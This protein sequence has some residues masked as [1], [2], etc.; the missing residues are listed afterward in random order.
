MDEDIDIEEIRERWKENERKKPRM[1]KIWMVLLMAIVLL[2]GYSAAS[3]FLF[4]HTIPSTSGAVLTTSCP[5]SLVNQNLPPTTGTGNILFMCSSGSAPIISNGGNAIPS[6]TGLAVGQTLNL[7]IHTTG[8]TTCAG[9]ILITSG[10]SMS[11][12][13]GS[14]DYCLESVPSPSPAVTISW[15]Q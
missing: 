12:A 13:S 4:S 10:V 8:A 9:G 1:R 7:V 14:F 5:G 6:V 2:A 3:V 11:I 15:S